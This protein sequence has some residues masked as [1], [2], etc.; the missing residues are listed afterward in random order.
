MKPWGGEV[1]G[2]E[3]GGVHEI[4]SSTMQFIDDR[5]EDGLIA[6][7]VS[8]TTIPQ[9]GG[10]PV[11]QFA[12]QTERI[13]H[14]GL[15]DSSDHHGLR[16]SPTP[17]AANPRTDPVDAHRSELVAQGRQFR[18]E[19]ASERDAAHAASLGTHA[20]GHEDREPAFAGDESDGI[21][22]VDFTRS[23]R[24]GTG[25]RHPAGAWP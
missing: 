10:S 23:P 13:M 21:H 20:P 25:F 18:I 2:N 5:S 16:R 3:G 15:G 4:D 7:I 8:Q 14:P 17:Q 12:N 9:P 19:V 11:R 6:S 24:E 22:A 1:V